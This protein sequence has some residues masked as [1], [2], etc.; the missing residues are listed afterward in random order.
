VRR[1]AKASTAGRTRRPAAGLGQI[2]HG[3]SAPA[4]RR[5]AIASLLALVTLVAVP[6][7]AFAAV[8]TI[9]STSVSA[10]TTTSALLEGKVDPEG[11]ATTYHF[12]YGAADCASNP[13]ASI[14]VPDAG[15]GSGSTPVKVGR[16]IDGLA[17]A[18]TYHYRLVAANPSGTT[19][20]PSKTFTTFPLQQLQTNC[21]NQLF[22]YGAGAQLPDCRAYEMVSPLDKN[23]ADIRNES[24][25]TRFYT[26]HFQAATGGDKFLYSSSISFGDAR[27][28]YYS[29]Q[30]I[31]TR[32]P[33]GW[34]THGINPPHLDGSIFSPELTGSDID[35]AYY[36]F[37]DDLS[38]A[39]LL[40][41]GLPPLDSDA[42]PNM[43]NLYKQDLIGDS[44]E[45]LTNAVPISKGE[46]AT[47][48]QSGHQLA[49]QG[50]SSD[51]SHSVFSG[52][53][54]FTPDAYP[55]APST[56]NP[57]QHEQLYDYHDGQIELVSILPDGTTNPTNGHVAG[58]QYQTYGRHRAGLYQHG[59]SAD[60]SRIF[61][62][63][64]PGFGAGGT[65]Y[66]RIDGDITV[67]ISLSVPGGEEAFFWGANPE[68][69]KVLFTAYSGG[70]AM[71]YSFDV[72]S[73]I[74][75]PL[76][77][78]V[79][80]IMGM[81]EDLSRIYFVS[82]APLAPGGTLG[83]RNL[84][85]YDEGTISHVTTLDPKDTFEGPDAIGFV[86][87]YNVVGYQDMAR[88]AV[89]SPDGRFAAFT[90]VK[91]LTGYDNTSVNDAD[92]P[93][94]EVYRYDA[95][96]D[97]LVCASCNPSGAR[98]VSAVPENPYNEWPWKD[99]NNH[100]V[101]A[102][103]IL[104]TAETRF[105]TPHTISD[106][107]SVVFFNS[108][109]ALVP[110]DT[111]GAED[112]YQWRAPGAGSCEVGGPGY[113]AQNEGCVSLISTGK[114][115][116]K[117]EFYDATP[118][119]STVFF[120]TGSSIDPRDPGLVDV[121]AARVNGGYPPPPAKP[122]PCTGDACQSVPAPPSA[123]MSASATFEGPGNRLEKFGRS[124]RPLAKQAA[125]L[126]RR[127]KRARGSGDQARA[128]ALLERAK[129][130]SRR[131]AR[132]RSANRRAGR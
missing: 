106:D 35:T 125:K 41:W 104:N 96:A 46:N 62:V 58:Y 10:V 28:S 51:G 55:I 67:P 25:P 91:S 77:T 130:K 124:C 111:N 115:T 8:P 94:T 43:V 44:F 118:D 37:N 81:S 100:R 79:S 123:P 2:C 74:V 102:A 112:V 69:T 107:G 73:K 32:G 131:A 76:A 127:A 119:G 13:C 85:L 26:R 116:E 50:A 68:G 87:P 23:G 9:T 34:T 132:C 83:E 64:K 105:R 3:D 114:S 40:D 21:P 30:Y 108:F 129:A 14:P 90:S 39:W 97:Q 6:S 4:A 60:G 75:T 15:L 122:N 47:S 52:Q 16:E 86:L 99:V 89:V 93:A 49:F 101:A 82:G 53:V 7:S 113:S 48:A 17:P 71:L 63:A 128:D 70:I 57:A 92:I 11:G 126:R 33:E 95:D 84:Y 42:A 98:P 38:T 1:H 24:T 5:A 27:G 45:A 120:E 117:S 59:V 80:G 110:Q 22:R 65:L 103:G 12:E 78:Q 18:T 31:A 56:Q 29:N 19:N 109:D 66:V 36:A 88:T 61:W 20:G 72:D 121:Y 54:A